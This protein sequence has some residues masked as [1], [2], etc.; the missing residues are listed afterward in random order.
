[1]DA[2]EATLE[3]VRVLDNI[4]SKYTPG[5]EM[6]ATDEAIVYDLVEATN[7]RA[8]HIWFHFANERGILT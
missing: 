7:K 5:D 4:L 6:S 8:R 2:T 1:M 3:N